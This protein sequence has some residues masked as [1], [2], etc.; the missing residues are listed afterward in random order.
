MHGVNGPVSNFQ[1]A[2]NHAPAQAL[3]ADHA[4]VPQAGPVQIGGGAL[5]GRTVAV[6]NGENN[7]IAHAA[8]AAIKSLVGGLSNAL[9][10]VVLSPVALLKGINA[11]VIKPCM[12]EFRSMLDDANSVGT[13]RPVHH[14]PAQMSALDRAAQSLNDRINRGLG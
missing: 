4:A 13:P 1:P 8:C 9:L 6:G 14:R 3:A 12:D 2:A 10:A 11:Y 7:R 5:Q